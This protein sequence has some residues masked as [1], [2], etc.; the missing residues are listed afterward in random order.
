MPAMAEKADRA[1][2]WQAVSIDRAEALLS[3]LRDGL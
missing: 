3:G 2:P 1:H